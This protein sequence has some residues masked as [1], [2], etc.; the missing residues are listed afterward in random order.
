MQLKGTCARDFR[1]MEHGDATRA[2]KILSDARVRLV[3]MSAATVTGL[4][5]EALRAIFVR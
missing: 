3:E 1:L 5:C 4:L 2:A